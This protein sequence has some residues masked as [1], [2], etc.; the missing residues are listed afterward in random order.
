M[1]PL[2]DKSGAAGVPGLNAEEK[3]T[4]DSVRE[5]VVQAVNSKVPAKYGRV[6]EVLLFLPDLVVLIFRLLKDPRVPALAKAKLAL[7]TVYL[8]SPIDLIPDFI[9]FIG[10]LDDL[11]VGVYV[12]RDILN[13]TPMAVVMEHWSGQG[14]VIKTT[15]TILDVAGEVL[16]KNVMAAIS[17]YLNR[18]N[19]KPTGATRTAESASSATGVPASAADSVPPACEASPKDPK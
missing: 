10:Q 1:E 11:V 19:Q 8:V 12:I 18:N 13:S 9:P 4:Y 16:G 15:Q 7:F 17:R 3:K 5:R 2:D 6:A 14:D